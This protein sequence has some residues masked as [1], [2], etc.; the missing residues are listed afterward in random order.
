MWMYFRL[1]GPGPVDVI[2]LCGMR[3]ELLRKLGFQDCFKTIKVRL[4]QKY[5]LYHTIC[6]ALTCQPTIVVRSTVRKAV[7]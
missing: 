4:T 6:I 2:K 1:E 5:P 7:R 3:D